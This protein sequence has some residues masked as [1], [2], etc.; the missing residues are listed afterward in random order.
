MSDIVGEL[1][2]DNVNKH[3]ADYGHLPNLANVNFEN[4]VVFVWNGTTS[5][6]KVP[7]GEWI[8]DNRK[9]LPSVMRPLQFLLWTCHGISSMSLHTPGKRFWEGSS[10]RNFNT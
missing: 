3:I 9:D 6:V 7:N 4:D 1:K 8:P 2:L 10:A 5:G